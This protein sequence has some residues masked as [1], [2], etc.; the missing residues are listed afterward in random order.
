MSDKF[1]TIM[2]LDDGRAAEE[3]N[4]A[5][6]TAALDVRSRPE[7][8]KP[9]KV[10]FELT[11]TP[12]DGGFLKIAANPKVTLPPNGPRRTLCSLPDEEGNMRDLNAIGTGQKSLP[13]DMLFPEDMKVVFEETE[14]EV[15]TAGG[16][17]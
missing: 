15:E 11:M 1:F 13:N 9:R 7:V 2:S 10:T 6:K 14:T 17:Q 5:I 12:Q 16:Q 4:Q 8:L 3:L